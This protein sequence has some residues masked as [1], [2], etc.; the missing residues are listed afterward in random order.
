MAG[1]GQTVK[2]GAWV[3]SGKLLARLFDL[4]LLLI[5]SRLLTP[6]DFGLLALAMAPILIGEALLEL[7]LAQALIRFDR[8]TKPMYDTAFTLSI[9]RGLA[10]ALIFACLAWPLAVFY[11]DPRLTSLICA[12]SIAPILRGTVSPRLVVFMKDMDFTRE[13]ALD[14]FGKLIAFAVATYI[15]LATKSYWAIAAATITAPLAMNILSY[16]FAPYKPSLTL[17]EWKKFIDMLGWNSVAQILSALNWQLDRLLLGRLVPTDTLGQYSLADDLVSIPFRS[18][19][20]PLARPLMVNFT[21]QKTNDSLGKAYVDSVKT[22]TLG[23]IP[24][25]LA[26]AALAEPIVYLVLGSKWYEAV[27]IIQW[28]ALVGILSVPIRIL[29]PLALS[30]DKTRYIAVQMAVELGVKLPATLAGIYYYGI[31]GAIAARG[32]ACVVV[33]VATVFIARKLIGISVWRQLLPLSKAAICMV[34]MG[35]VL[36]LTRPSIDF[37]ALPSKFSLITNVVVCG[38]VSSA[39]YLFS[40]FIIWVLSGKPD[41]VESY[42]IEHTKNAARRFGS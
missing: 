3:I 41:G 18:F 5:L 7:P 19:V 20:T 14:F 4:A 26:I 38:V 13:F 40:V 1:K 23:M 33:G 39:A 37:S 21:L 22:V 11:D 28:I 6:D 16:Y 17:S 30:L 10:L 8:P 34:V 35:T 36:L 27:P 9:I 2:A 42:V 31:W 29:S 12:L 32:L 24:I 15:A 25:L